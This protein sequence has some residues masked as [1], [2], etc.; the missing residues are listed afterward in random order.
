[1]GLGKTVQTLAHL[2]IDQASGRLTG[3]PDRLPDQS[4]PELDGEAQRFAPD[5]VA[6]WRCTGHAQGTVPGDQSTTSC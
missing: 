3:R 4:D 6:C 1:M 5:L 2:M